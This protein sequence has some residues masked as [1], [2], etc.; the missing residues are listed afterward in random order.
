V[1]SSNPPFS[2]PIIRFPRELKVLAGRIA[3]VYKTEIDGVEGFFIALQVKNLDNLDKF[4]QDVVEDNQKL[5]QAPIK[6]S[7]LKIKGR[8]RDSEPVTSFS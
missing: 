4:V 7:T 1:Q 2:Y 6:Q 3:N 5:F 8:G